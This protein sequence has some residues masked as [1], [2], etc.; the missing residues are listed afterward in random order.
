M[1]I[2]LTGAFGF[3][4]SNVLF[5][6]SRSNDITAC[7]Y[8]TPLN[9]LNAHKSIYT[10][11][12]PLD[13]YGHDFSQYE[14]IIHMG[15]LSSTTEKDGSLVYNENVKLTLFLHQVAKSLDI[16]FIYASSASI[17]GSGC[18][19]FIDT[20]DLKAH[21]DYRPL[22]LYAWSKHY[23]DQRLI[24]TDAFSNNSKTYGLRFFNMFGPREQSKLSTGSVLSQNIDAISRGEAVSLFRNSS[25]SSHPVE[26]ARDFTYV[27]LAISMI[28]HIIENPTPSSI[29]NVG[30]GTA[31]TFSQHIESAFLAFNKKP[32]I[33]YI[34][35]PSTL[36]DQYQFFTQ[37]DIS[38]S[39]F[40]FRNLWPRDEG[41]DMHDYIKRVY[42]D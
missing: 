34:D 37:A 8:L 13:V 6:L 41:A 11:L 2:F 3:I 21:C 5:D 38:K 32:N 14:A 40:V 24:A 30:T 17:Y 27:G 25:S 1:K 7:D 33:K 20:I 4:G 23:V 12:S 39:R 16:I 26:A 29:Y 9:I 28:K 15:A 22:N 31:C 35:I 10:Y 36:L 42:C 18:N 19:G